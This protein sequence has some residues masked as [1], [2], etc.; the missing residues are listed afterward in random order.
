MQKSPVSKMFYSIRE[1]AALLEE[2][3]STLRYWESEFREVIAPRRNERR[4]RLYTEKD[5]DNARLIKHLIRD[6]GLTFEGVRK[7]LNH[8]N[9]ESTI[10]QARVVQRL[11]QIKAE[12]TALKEALSEAEKMTLQQI[13]ASSPNE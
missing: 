12:L 10:K 8:N 5:I 9:I 6:C 3:E 13:E 7:R 2:T 1:V 11:K 4:V